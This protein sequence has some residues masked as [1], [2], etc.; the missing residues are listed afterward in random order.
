[1]EEQRK[2][3]EEKFK[4]AVITAQ[5]LLKDIGE[6]RNINFPQVNPDEEPETA[7]EIVKMAQNIDERTAYILKGLLIPY[8][9][10]LFL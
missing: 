3:I 6:M 4:T 2:E 8:G 1:M 10:A 5:Q 7:K 9:G